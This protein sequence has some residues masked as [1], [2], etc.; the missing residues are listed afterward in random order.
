MK[1]F[2]ASEKIIFAETICFFD[3]GRVEESFEDQYTTRN[4]AFF[5]VREKAPVQKSYIHN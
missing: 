5:D 1:E 2:I 4:E 3:G